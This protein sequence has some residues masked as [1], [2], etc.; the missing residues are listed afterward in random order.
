MVNRAIAPKTKITN[1]LEF[2]DPEL[3][4]LDNDIQGYTFASNEADLIKIEIVIGSG[5]F[6][7]HKHLVTP[8]TGQMLNEG[9]KQHKS[10]EIQ[11]AM[12]F[13]GTS[14][15]VESHLDNTYVVI[16][17]LS[18]NISKSMELVK[19]MLIDS[20]FPQKEFEIMIEN[21]KK[22]I[23]IRDE[24]VLSFALEKYNEC[25]FGT[26]HPYGYITQL[27][28]YDKL[29]TDDLKK[30]YNEKLTSNKAKIILS[31]KVTAKLITE[32]NSIFGQ[33]WEKQNNDQI[34]NLSRKLSGLISK[35]K[36]VRIEK[37]D[38][39]QVAVVIGGLTIPKQHEDSKKLGLMLAV[40]GGGS[41]GSRLNKNLRIDKGYTYGV[42]ARYQ[43]YRNLGRL[44]ISGEFKKDSVDDTLKQIYFEID[45]LKQDLITEEE[46]LTFKN[47]L[48]GSFMNTLDGP[49]AIANAYKNELIYGLDFQYYTDYMK[50]VANATT[51]DVRDIAQKYLN[52]DEMYEIVVG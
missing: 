43:A 41:L 18:K 11:E 44:Y 42:Y 46:L 25:L 19:E 13:L 5:N 10:Y 23:K 33:G 29:T 15:H 36:K 8:L 39:E 37:K 27:E 16:K 47:K 24:N 51:E 12:E 40:L 1:E 6:H 52:N 50:Y 20:I 30:F 17:S 28:N 9:T 2:R 35:E 31:G 14:F 26:Q 4:K 21:N 38:K 48:I 3:F 22:S 34:S 49:F 32:I 45:R 7:E